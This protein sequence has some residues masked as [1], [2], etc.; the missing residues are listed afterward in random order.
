VEYSQRKADTPRQSL[1]HIQRG[2][3]LD[4]AWEAEGHIDMDLTALRIALTAA[5]EITPQD[6]DAIQAV[7]WALYQADQEPSHADPRL[8][9]LLEQLR[10]T[11]ELEIFNGWMEVIAHTASRVTYPTLAWWLLARATHVGVEQT[12][13]NLIRFLTATELPYRAT[14]ALGG[15]TPDSACTLGPNITLLPWEELPDSHRKRESI[16]ML[17]NLGVFIMP[18]AALVRDV[19][20]PRLNVP[21]T[22]VRP[23]IITP[24]AVDYTD[25]RDAL[26]C[27][28][29]VGPV[30]P[31]ELFTWVEPPEWAPILEIA[32]GTPS[33][34][35]HERDRH[36]RQW[37]SEGARQVWD[38]CQKLAQL[39][40]NH[41]ELMRLRMRRLNSAMR[42]QDPV[43]A[44]IDLGITL[45]SLFLNDPERGELTFQL[46]LRAARVLGRDYDDR[47]RVFN[48]VND[49]YVIRSAAVHSGHIPSLKQLRNRLR[50]PYKSGTTEDL[51]KA[52]FTLAAEAIT[53]FLQGD[54]P[55]QDWLKITLG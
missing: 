37:P 9:R 44:A 21:E 16:A 1:T 2:V 13:D 48:L 38:L 43:D 49:L 5:L 52:G 31:Y 15:I 35:F 25:L 23:G 33:A 42:R 36:S 14:L 55:Q 18:T 47:V 11:P 34:L 12:L 7:R 50:S 53:A 19:T 30:A 24:V 6:G 3:C 17:I 28:G 22:A 29:L 26:L 46:R 40:T 20:L 10:Q 45:E 8:V 4:V 51:L 54:Q 41:R 32:L 39:P 27:I